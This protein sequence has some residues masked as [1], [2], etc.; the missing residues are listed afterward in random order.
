MLFT[1]VEIRT[2]L[3]QS[4]DPSQ[5]PESPYPQGLLHDKLF[6]AAVLIPLLI[7][8]DAWHLLFIRRTFQKNDSHSGQVAYPGGRSDPDDHNAEHTAKREAFEEI[9]IKP[10]DIR[11]LGRLGDMV[12]ITGYNVTPVIQC[13]A[14][15]RSY[16]LALSNY[17][18]AAGS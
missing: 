18:P 5:F 15:R 3:D 1:E 8:D 6:P 16:P 11:V 4:F 7:K 9:G 10:D 13:H 2:L 17:P 12:T 14:C